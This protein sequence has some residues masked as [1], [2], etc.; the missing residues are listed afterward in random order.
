M[1]LQR[2]WPAINI[3]KEIDGWDDDEFLADMRLPL[4]MAFVFRDGGI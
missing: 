1:F 3:Q 2:R 4:S